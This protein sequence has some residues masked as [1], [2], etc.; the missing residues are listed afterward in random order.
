VQVFTTTVDEEGKQCQ[1][2]EVSVPVACLSHW[3]HSLKMER[4]QDEIQVEKK[5]IYLFEYFYSALSLCQKTT[6]GM[7]WAQHM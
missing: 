7:N 1:R 3:S 2:A 4:Y 5:S 6:L